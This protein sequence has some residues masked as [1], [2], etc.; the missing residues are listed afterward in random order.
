M[1]GETERCGCRRQEGD[2]L[3][4][5]LELGLVSSSNCCVKKFSISKV[6]PKA[7]CR[8][9]TAAVL[10]Q[11]WYDKEMK[12]SNSKDAQET[13]VISFQPNRKLEV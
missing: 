13:S 5:L 12:Y 8:C 9:E 10:W 2:V 4:V 1:G 3:A 7:I 6:R 11:T